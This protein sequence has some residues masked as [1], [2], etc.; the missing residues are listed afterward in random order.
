VSVLG[1]NYSFS[2]KQT[3]GYL[4]IPVLVKYYLP[5]SATKFNVYAGPSIGFLLNAKVLVNE[6][7]SSTESDIKDQTSRTDFG[8]VLGTGIGFPIGGMDATI[9][10]RYD[11]GL[12]TLDKSG[13]SNAYNRVFSIIAGVSL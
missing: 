11:L 6:N 2:A 3:S 9:E 7:G 1:S 8:V 5:G 4:D 12:S 10:A 13:N